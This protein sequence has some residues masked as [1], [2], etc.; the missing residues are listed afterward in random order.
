MR[1]VA[2]ASRAAG[3]RTRRATCA[4]NERFEDALGMHR[5]IGIDRAAR[6]V[7][8]RDRGGIA[9][10][11]RESTTPA[12]PLGST[13]VR[14]E[15]RERIGVQAARENS[16]GGCRKRQRARQA[17]AGIVSADGTCREPRRWTRTLEHVIRRQIGSSDAH[18]CKVQHQRGRLQSS[19][20]RRQ[21]AEDRRQF[22]RA[23]RGH[24]GVRPT[25][26]R[27]R[28]SRGRST[29]A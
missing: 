13:L 19:A 2:P 1:A 4:G 12:A 7:A 15:H 22:R 11:T 27:A 8:N 29:T 20:V 24:Q 14:A 26:R 16:S 23:R 28:R 6:Q 21:G 18:V 17:S 25:R 3:S 9:V 10:E 5:V